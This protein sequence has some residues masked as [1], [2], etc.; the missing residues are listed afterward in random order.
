MVERNEHNDNS[1]FISLVFLDL[2]KMAF[3]KLQTVE[4]RGNYPKI[5]VNKAEP[6]EF[7]LNFWIDDGR[8]IRVCK[9]DGAKLIIGE[10][11]R[12][13]LSFQSYYNGRLYSLEWIGDENDLIEVCLLFHCLFHVLL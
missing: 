3:L 12:V 8:F 4:L 13:D 1:Y 7:F 11:I 5:I 10:A 6:T 2:R 9:V